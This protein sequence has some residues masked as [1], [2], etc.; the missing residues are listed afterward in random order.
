MSCPFCRILI[1]IMLYEVNLFNA[2][3]GV[4]DSLRNK[5]YF[6]SQLGPKLLTASCTTPSPKIRVIESPFVTQPFLSSNMKSTAI[7]FSYV[8]PVMNSETFSPFAR[9]SF[10]KLNVLS[11]RMATNRVQSCARV[12]IGRH[13]STKYK[14]FLIKTD[15]IDLQYS[16]SNFGKQ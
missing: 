2:F 16:K 15:Q 5:A 6:P 11:W 10:R 8:K 1:E 14:S 7:T 9:I 4:D 13:T 3:S 12:T